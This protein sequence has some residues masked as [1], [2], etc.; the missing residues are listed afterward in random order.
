M[1]EKKEM[2]AVPAGVAFTA[3]GT[4]RSEPELLRKRTDEYFVDRIATAYKGRHPM[5]SRIPGPDAIQVRTNDYLCISSDP[6]LIEAEIEALKAVGHGNSI[7]RVWVHHETTSLNVFEKRLANL[8][9]AED[10]V[11]CNSGYGANVG[12]LQ[13]VAKPETP[14]YIDMTAHLSLWEGVTSARAT[15]H[16]FRHNDASHLE[17][18]VKE[19]GPGVIAVDALYS[20]NGEMCPLAD[21]ADIADR[22]G[23]VLVVDETHSFG[24]HGP[25]GAGLV[26]AL[27]LDDRVP[28]RTIGLSKAV[29]S[30]GGAIVCSKRNAEFIRFEAFPAIFS[31]SVLPHEVAGYN[32]ALDIFETDGWRRLRLHENHAKIKSGLTELGYNVEV[33]DSQILALESGTY[34]ATIA[35][36]DALETRGIFGSIFFPPAVPETRCMIRLTINCGLTSS[37]VARVIEVCEEIRDEVGMADWKST[38]RGRGMRR[39]SSIAKPTART[40]N[41]DVGVA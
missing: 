25:D 22:Y 20:T 31:T 16:P 38:R 19:G 24:T 7:S 4:S 28:F 26:S 6:R 3:L 29:A 30:R 15:P 5:K 21:F 39:P 10:A 1:V 2:R 34:D 41:L 18:K 9:G 17:R 35:L 32:A 11:L 37:Q 27:G 40:A 36:R 23:C 8:M 13:A 33:C 14:I 12:V